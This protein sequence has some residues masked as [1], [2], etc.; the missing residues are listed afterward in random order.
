V[1][2]NQL[3]DGPLGEHQVH[4]PQVDAAFRD[5]LTGSRMV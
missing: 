1:T 5:G 4:V 2:L 3:G